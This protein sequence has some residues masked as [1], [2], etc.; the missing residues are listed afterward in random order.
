[1]AVVYS[2]HTYSTAM[3]GGKLFYSNIYFPARKILISALA[4]YKYPLTNVI[5]NGIVDNRV[6][7]NTIIDIKGE[8]MAVKDHLLDEKITKAAMEAFKEKNFLKASLNKIAKRQDL[9]LVRYIHA[10][11]AR[12]S[13]FAASSVRLLRRCRNGSI[14]FKK[15]TAMSGTAKILRVF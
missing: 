13:F 15:H 4:F 9:Q 5:N 10:T 6:I 7:D 3:D 11:K 12:M 2:D 1:M 8:Y 14:R